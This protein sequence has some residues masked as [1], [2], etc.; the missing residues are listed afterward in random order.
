MKQIRTK[1][2]YASHPNKRILKVNRYTQAD[3]D[4]IRKNFRLGPVEISLKLTHLTL[5]QIHYVMDYYDLR[6]YSQ[7]CRRFRKVLA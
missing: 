3:V 1:E 7:Y 4:F 2:W 5:P 6:G